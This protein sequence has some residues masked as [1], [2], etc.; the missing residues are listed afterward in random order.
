MNNDNNLIYLDFEY[1]NLIFDSYFELFSEETICNSR[2]YAPIYIGIR[3]FH[4]NLLATNV[5]VFLRCYNH[6]VV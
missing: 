1:N 4:K 3:K 6:M 5:M 2:I